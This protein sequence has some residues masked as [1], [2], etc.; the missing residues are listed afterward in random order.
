MYFD[1]LIIP[2]ERKQKI[3]LTVL[4]TASQIL[5]VE[6]CLVSYYSSFTRCSSLFTLESTQIPAY[7]TCNSIFRV[8]AYFLVTLERD[9]PRCRQVHPK[10]SQVYIRVIRLANF[11]IFCVRV[12]RLYWYSSKLVQ[13]IFVWFALRVR[14]A[15]SVQKGHEIPH[16]CDRRELTQRWHYSC[17][18]GASSVPKYCFSPSKN[19]TNCNGRMIC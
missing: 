16:Q 15:L 2:L 14:L 9:D 17:C 18:Y 6:V 7:A 10:A 19:V 13:K 4:V 1:L 3:P 11:A 8:M 5:G 12:I